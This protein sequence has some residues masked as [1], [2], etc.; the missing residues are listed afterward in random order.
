MS[1]NLK[2]KQIKLHK[3]KNSWVSND[4]IMKVKRQPKALDNIFENYV[5][6]KAII[7]RFITGQLTFN[8]TTIKFN[9]SFKMQK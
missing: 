7:F 9:P 5:S 2:K 8:S 6:Y 4:I 3:I 1:K